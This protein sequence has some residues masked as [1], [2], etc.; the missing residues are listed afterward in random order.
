MSHTGFKKIVLKQG[1]VT[2]LSSQPILTQ[3]GE[4]S[5]HWLLTITWHGKWWEMINIIK[6]RNFGT[7][8]KKKQNKEI[9]GG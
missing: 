3:Q 9:A 7:I 2:L 5:C 8:T 4:R 1:I 6:W